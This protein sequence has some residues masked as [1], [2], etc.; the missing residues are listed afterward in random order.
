MWKQ[1]VVVLLA[2]LPTA[3]VVQTEG[4]QGETG[5]Q[6]EKGDP[7]NEGLPGQSGSQGATGPQG[8]TGETGPMGEPGMS[9][10]TYIDASMTDISYSG[11]RVGI[12]TS[13]PQRRLHVADPVALIYVQDSDSKATDSPL[14]AAVSFR[15]SDDLEVGWVGDG[16]T[17]TTVQLR[18]TQGYELRLAASSGPGDLSISPSGEVGIGTTSPLTLVHIQGAFQSGA[19]DGLFIENTSTNRFL[20]SGWSSTYPRLIGDAGLGFAGLDNNTDAMFIAEKNVGIGTTSPEAPL[21]IKSSSSGENAT[22][23]SENDSGD[24]TYIYTGRSG[25]VAAAG[26]TVIENF[27]PQEVVLNPSGGR[28][29]IGTPSPAATL[30]VNGTARLAKYSSAPF[31]CDVAHDGTIALKDDYSLCVCKGA[32]SQWISTATK[33]SCW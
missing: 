19:A 31:A 24:S 18:A 28:V 11:G 15:D 1:G 22:L 32:Q 13:N 8:P 12:G 14:E 30:D 25:N 33:T 20:R 2:W 5:P 10:F 4:V 21:H 16:G 3:C 9:P 6:G 7:G 17:G 26:K 29:G 27:G 23:I